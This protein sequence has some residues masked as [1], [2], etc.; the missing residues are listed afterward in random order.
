MQCRIQERLLP[1]SACGALKPGLGF[2]LQGIRNIPAITENQ[3]E[4]KMDNNME[5]G[6]IR[7]NIGLVTGG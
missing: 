1:F 3:M 6:P 7:G 5:T 2:Y 4:K